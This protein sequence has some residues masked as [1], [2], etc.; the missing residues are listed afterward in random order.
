[1]KKLDQEIN[2]WKKRYDKIH[3][4][5]ARLEDAVEFG[6]HQAT[7]QQPKRKY[8]VMWPVLSAIAVLLLFFGSVRVSPAF[9]EKI[10][11][12]PGMEKIVQLI[13]GDQGKR[14][15]IDANHFQPLGITQQKGDL[16][17]T[18]EGVI[19]D[20]YGMVIFYSLEAEGDHRNLLLKNPMFTAGNGDELPASSVSY[21]GGHVKENDNMRMMEV[22]T[23][24]GMKGIEDFRLAME[25][26]GIIDGSFVSEEFSITF[27][28]PNE[29]E[30]K[31]YQVDETVSIEGEQFIVESVTVHP[32]RTAIK[33][34]EHPDNQTE[35]LSIEDLEL[36][37]EDGE[38]WTSISNGVS[39]TGGPEN[40]AITFYLQSNYFEDPKSLTLAF[41]KVMVV[42]PEKEYMEI[43]LEQEEIIYQPSDFAELTYASEATFEVVMDEEVA[44]SIGF[45][46][47]KDQY[48]DSLDMASQQTE[49]SM[50]GPKTIYTQLDEEAEGPVRIEF[51]RYP[52]WVEKEVEI[53]LK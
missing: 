21:S 33:V 25:G 43:D 50:E 42:N 38:V 31:E 1:M 6:F 48:G 45:S 34:R 53:N 12:V 29:A 9:A 41:S 18:V 24:D 14:A 20:N 47:I 2:E 28:A 32:L 5:E 13:Q 16:T 52:E 22:Y 8:K 46:S 37:G 19:R 26:S 39:A 10:S 51:S 11:Q 23:Q 44:E 15:A 35:M 4:E 17:L 30:S 3:M 27:E 49:M 36:R 40:D 7:K